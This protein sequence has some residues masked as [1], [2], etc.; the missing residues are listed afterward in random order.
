MNICR[1]LGVCLVVCLL[2]PA[3]CSDKSDKTDSMPTAAAQ[4]NFD[5]LVFGKDI[6]E[7]PIELAKWYRKRADQGDA[8]AQYTLGAMYARGEGVPQDDTKSVKWHRKAADQGYA[9]GQ[10]LLGLAYRDGLGV[11]QDYAEGMKWIRL[12][13]EQGSVLSQCGLGLCYLHGTGVPQDYA[14]AYAWFS[15]AAAGGYAEAVTKRDLVAGELTPEHLL[16][17]QKRATELF[18]KI[19]SGK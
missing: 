5:L 14:E 9:K 16:Q 13:A 11:P 6:P 7:D 2:S 8:E 10:F 3:G 4:S 15:V 1:T 19:G 17:A 18:E 12:A